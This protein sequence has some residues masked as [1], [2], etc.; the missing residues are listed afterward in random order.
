MF[1]VFNVFILIDLLAI[2]P[3]VGNIVL[4]LT[5]NYIYMPQKRLTFRPMLCALGHRAV[6]IL[7]YTLP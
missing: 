3:P 4:V 6:R 2:K 5:Q 1:S 7:L